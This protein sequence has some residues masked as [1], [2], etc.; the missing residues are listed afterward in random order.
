MLQP[1]EFTIIVNLSLP[2]QQKAERWLNIQH[3]GK[4]TM[5]LDVKCSKE[6]VKASH[7]F[8]GGRKCKVTIQIDEQGNWFLKQAEIL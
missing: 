4:P 6:H 2:F 1:N 7:L 8:H 5:P 3:Y